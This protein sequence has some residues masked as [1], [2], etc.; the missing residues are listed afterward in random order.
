M[1]ARAGARALAAAAVLCACGARPAAG[2]GAAGS[3]ILYI[4][5]NVRDAQVYLDG[6]FIAPLDSLRGG[7]AVAAGTHRLE[8]RHE[9]YFSSYAE[10]AVARAE[11]RRLAIELAEV[12]P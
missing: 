10:V 9:D 8:L 5:S 11:R 3:A 1:A 2:R 4:Q 6:T 12:L 7:I